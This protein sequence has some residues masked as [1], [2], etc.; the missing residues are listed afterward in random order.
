LLR[1]RWAPAY[2]REAEERETAG[3]P[4]RAKEEGDWIGTDADFSDILGQGFSNL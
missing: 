3:K 2:G 1:T 4:V